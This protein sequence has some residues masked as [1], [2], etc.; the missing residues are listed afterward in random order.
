[1]NAS[2]TTWWSGRNRVEI[3]RRDGQESE[4]AG[5]IASRRHKQ[6]GGAGGRRKIAFFGHFDGTNFG[7]ESSLQAILYHLRRREPPVQVTCICS[8]PR[9]TASTYRIEALPFSGVFSKSSAPRN[10]MSRVARKVYGSLREPF[11][12]I[13]CIHR[14]RGTEMLVVP[15][16]GLLTDAYGLRGWGPYGLLRWS[17]IAKAC[18]CKVALVSVGAGPVHG[19]IGKWCIRLILSLASFCSYR[20]TSSV[21][22]LT[23]IGLVGDGGSIFPDLAFS[24]PECM[25]P[26]PSRPVE[27]RPVVGLGVM[28]YSGTY[29]VG[30]AT[31]AAFQEYL[32]TLVESSKW[33]L[34]RGYN[35]RLLSGD[36]AD[37]GA[38]RAFRLVLQ[39]RLPAYD[40]DRIIDEPVTSVTDLL[41]HIASTDFVVATR[42]HNIVFGFL[43]GKPVISISFHHKCES[44]MAMMGM[45]DYCLEMGGLKADRL[46]DTLSRLEANAHLLGPS[47]RERTAEFRQALDQQYEMLFGATRQDSRALE[48]IADQ[49][50]ASFG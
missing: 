25:I 4:T 32:D 16:T 41:S 9:I 21:R 24:L 1:M 28:E 11:R 3:L 20:D 5:P 47:V 18:G 45:S 37:A 44:L 12:W 38:R 26:R 29:K 6:N 43:C 19:T 34:D 42:F 17:L 7:N 36:A 48:P 2:T 33:L 30:D 49:G 31:N 35:I 22:C 50:T 46:I 23:G 27:A 15:G 13:R 39:E 8:G 14:L 10:P 40:R